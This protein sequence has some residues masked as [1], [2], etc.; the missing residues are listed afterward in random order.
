MAPDAIPF[1]APHF[2]IFSI[3]VMGIKSALVDTDLALDTPLSVSFY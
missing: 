2:I 1:T 3:I